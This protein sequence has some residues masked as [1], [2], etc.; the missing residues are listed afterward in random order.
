MNTICTHIIALCCSLLLLSTCMSQNRVPQRGRGKAVSERNNVKVTHRESESNDYEVVFPMNEY[1]ATQ[2]TS[3][4]PVL[5]AGKLKDINTASFV[6]VMDFGAAG[7]GA[8]ADDKAI[9]KAFDAC[10]DGSGVL[11]PKGKTFLIH[12]LIRTP[13]NKNITVYAYDATFIMDKGTGYNAIA[14]E[15][16]ANAY[17]NQV[18]WLGGTFDGNK[19]NQSWPGSPGGSNAWTV[20][21][22]NYGLLTIRGAKFA[23]VKDVHITN[24]VY[25]GVNLF[26][27][28]L[29]AIAD[30]K[31]DNGVN[32][33]YGKIRDKF[34][35][36]HQS[37]YFKCTRRNSQ[38]VYFMNLDCREGSIGVQYST[39]TVSDSSLAVVNNCNFYNQ[40]QD[41]IHFESCR[42]IFINQCTIGADNN[43][44]Y[45][46]KLHISNSC[47]LASIKNS[48]FTNGRITFVNASN[49]QLGI[50]ENCQFASSIPAGDARQLRNFVQNA[51]HIK[52][53]SFTG[54]T[55]EEQATAKYI[56]SS[57]FKN[58]KIAVAAKKIVNQCVF[59]NGETAV[60]KARFAPYISDCTFKN[61]GS[62]ASEN[63]S[64][65]ENRLSKE[66]LN[67]MFSSSIKIVDQRK[68]MLGHISSSM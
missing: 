34:N 33:N 36:G 28:E 56:S 43:K 17:N 22:P 52:N 47:V 61:M 3:P 16:A 58:F 60:N 6:N 13:L 53:C 49:L 65:N 23:L 26:E 62:S 38:V 45:E 42:R 1:L 46:A 40:G 64:S 31:G 9:A 29:G 66:T 51:T 44:D 25:D 63:N 20:T 24:T 41:A 55:R 48:R 4:Y 59:S 11:F 57:D 14:F 7:N 35:E 32:L 37:T 50:V 30:S 68:K 8:K 2:D 21:Q 15:G 12:N 27:C 5:V 19:N 67:K 10:R 54:I 39:N 18:I